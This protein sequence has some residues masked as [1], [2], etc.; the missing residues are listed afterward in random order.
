MLRLFKL[1]VFRLKSLDS[2]TKTQ[3]AANPELDSEWLGRQGDA[4]ADADPEARAS[5]VLDRVSISRIFDFLG[6]IDGVREVT[7]RIEQRTR[8]P[9]ASQMLDGNSQL[10][11]ICEQ[12]LNCPKRQTS[13]MGKKLEVPDSDTENEDDEMLFE[14]ADRLA[15]EN[16]VEKGQESSRQ[17]RGEQAMPNDSSN[18]NVEASQLGMLIVD[19]ITSTLSSSMKNNYVQGMFSHLGAATDPGDQC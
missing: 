4:E 19:N 18:P 10:L 14:I 16:P 1:L 11:A 2:V 5:T 3:Q 12:N 8:T 17:C 13:E 9:K 15:H 6:V 7:D